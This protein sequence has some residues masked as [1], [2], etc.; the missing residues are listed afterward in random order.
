MAGGIRVFSN[1]QDWL[2]MC[3]FDDVM[4]NKCANEECDNMII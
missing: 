2:V 1:V 4:M 3:G